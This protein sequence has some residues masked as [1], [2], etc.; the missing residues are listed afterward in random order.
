MRAFYYY[1]K[2]HTEAPDLDGEIEAE[3]K[4]EA[5]EKFLTPEWRNLGWDEEMLDNDFMCEECLDA[6]LDYCEH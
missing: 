3:T 5:I 1:L 2:S 6:G 4:K